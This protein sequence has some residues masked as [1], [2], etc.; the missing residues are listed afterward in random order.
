M[1]VGKVVSDK[2]LISDCRTN[3]RKLTQAANRG[4]FTAA[5]EEAKALRYNLEVLRVKGDAKH[6]VERVENCSPADDMRRRG[7]STATIRRR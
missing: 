7:R 2:Q 5:F 6:E 3:A 1:P 4:D